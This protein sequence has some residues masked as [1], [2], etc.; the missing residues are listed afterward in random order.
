MAHYLKSFGNLEHDPERVLGT[1]F[2]HCAIE[3]PARQLAKSG[4]YLAGLHEK[5]HLIAAEKVKRINALMT[6]CG[7]YNES[8]DFAFRVGMPAKSGVGGGMLIIAPGRAS[9]AIW[10][11]GLNQNGNSN[12]GL[13]AAQELSERLR[14]QFY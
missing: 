7:L 11:P 4:R 14:L 12:A 1:Y 8:G 5:Y 6:A 10:S 13:F 9:I 2:H 3:I